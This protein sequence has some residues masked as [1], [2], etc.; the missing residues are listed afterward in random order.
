[1]LARLNHSGNDH[2]GNKPVKIQQKFAPG[3]LVI[4]P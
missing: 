2:T 1:M 4:A 3:R